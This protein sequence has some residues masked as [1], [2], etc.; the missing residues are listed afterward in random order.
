MGQTSPGLCL[1]LFQRHLKFNL[2]NMRFYCCLSNPFLFCISCLCRSGHQVLN[3]ETFPQTFIYLQH[4]IIPC[5]C[6]SHLLPF[7]TFSISYVLKYIIY[8]NGNATKPSSTLII[9]CGGFHKM[10]VYGTC[11]GTC[12]LCLSAQRGWKPYAGTT[13]HIFQSPDW[14]QGSIPATCV[15]AG[16]LLTVL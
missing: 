2:P 15:C 9:F 4:P 3:P 12:C 10:N 14:R 5:A 7:W 1:L 8:L 11:D 13:P 16:L 6:Q